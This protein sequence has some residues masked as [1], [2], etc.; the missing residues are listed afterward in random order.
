VVEEGGMDKEWADDHDADGVLFA[1]NT[2]QIAVPEGNPAEVTDLED[3]ADD[4]VTVAL[5]AEEV[6]CGAATT[7]AMEDSGTR[8]VPATY[9]DDVRAV[10][11]KVELGEVDAGLVYTD[12][13]STRLNSS[14]VSISYAVFCLK[15]KKTN[16]IDI[17]YTSEC[18]SSH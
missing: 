13:K 7:T 15:K 17:R 11:T 2:L 16:Q 12:R 18:T 6:P 4:D 10:L 3:L 14:H 9:E 5:C 8:I 1:V